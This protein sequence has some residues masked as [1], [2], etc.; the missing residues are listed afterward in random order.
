MNSGYTERYCIKMD[1]IDAF[2]TILETNAVYV[3]CVGDRVT[4]AVYLAPAVAGQ[5]SHC[6][7]YRQNLMYK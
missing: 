7:R 5:L 1:R 2:C 6:R 3:T 4:H